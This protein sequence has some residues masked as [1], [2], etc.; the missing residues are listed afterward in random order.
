MSPSGRRLWSKDG[1]LAKHGMVVSPDDVLA[2]NAKVA[3][4]FT[5]LDG[6]QLK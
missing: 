6:A 3:T 4:E 1:L 2:A 5:L